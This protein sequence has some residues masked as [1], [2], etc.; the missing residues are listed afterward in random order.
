MSENHFVNQLQLAEQDLG[1]YVNVLNIT[2]G[3]RKA[4]RPAQPY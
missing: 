1:T 2:L 3:G 4:W